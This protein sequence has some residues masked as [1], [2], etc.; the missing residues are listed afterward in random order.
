MTPRGATPASRCAYPGRGTRRLAGRS[1][2]TV[3]PRRCRRPQSGAEEGGAPR[4][5][6]AGRSRVPPIPDTVLDAFQPPDHGFTS[7]APGVAMRPTL[8]G[9]FPVR[10]SPLQATPKLFPTGRGTRVARCIRDAQTARQGVDFTDEE[11]MRTACRR[12][13]IPGSSDRPERSAARGAENDPPAD[14]CPQS[15]SQPE[16]GPT[17]PLDFSRSIIDAEF[18]R[19]G[20]AAAE[21][22]IAADHGLARSTI[23]FSSPAAISN[24][25][26]S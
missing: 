1:A 2:P 18:L 15:R 10:Y 11:T 13:A 9:E 22:S 5:R 23:S 6:L 17:F 25:T 21:H 16:V 7:R 12:A 19:S 24:V 20:S 4:S 26:S 8:E 14:H 3:P